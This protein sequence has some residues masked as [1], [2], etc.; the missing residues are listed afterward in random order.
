MSAQP[1]SL[2]GDVDMPQFVKNITFASGTITVTYDSGPPRDIRVLDFLPAL[3]YE[4]VDAVKILTNLI[5][6]L[7]RTLIAKN[8]LDEEF[9]AGV[10][11]V[12]LDHLIYV[13]EK[14]GGSYHNPDISVDNL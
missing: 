10:D 14:I 9:M 4:Q 1:V 2:Q 3:T 5:V 6:V 11:N 12:D 8:V 7:I 13:F